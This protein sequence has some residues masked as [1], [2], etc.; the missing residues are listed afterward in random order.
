MATGQ[1]VEAER[2]TTTGALVA[3]RPPVEVLGPLRASSRFSSPLWLPS[4]RKDAP[5]E[6]ETPIDDITGPATGLIPAG[7]RVD[8]GSRCGVAFD[9][10]T[11]RLPAVLV[12]DAC[13]KGSSGTALSAGASA[14]P[15]CRSFPWPP[16]PW[17]RNATSPT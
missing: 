15:P 5:S 2:Q 11:E 3:P 4:G 14:D 16:S 1:V 7:G 12:A 6:V 13:G 17:P 9:A 10:P 8:H